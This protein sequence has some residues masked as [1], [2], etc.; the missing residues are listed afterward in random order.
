MSETITPRLLVDLAVVAAAVFALALYLRERRRSRG[1]EQATGTVPPTV[2]SAEIDVDLIPSAAGSPRSPVNPTVAVT[3]S[4]SADAI[5]LGYP[6]DPL[7]TIRPAPDFS[8]DTLE[9]L[10][11]TDDLRRNLQHLFE[12]APRA[13]IASTELATELTSRRYLLIFSKDVRTRLST[14]AYSY[15]PISTEVGPPG[16]RSLAVD[17]RSRKFIEQGRLVRAINPAVVVGVVFQLASIATAQKYLADIEKR[18]AGIE[19][20]VGEL[21]RFQRH[22][23]DA[24]VE[25]LLRH[26]HRMADM[27]KSCDLT[28]RSLAVYAIKLEDL[29]VEGGR[30]MGQL[31]RLFAD[32]VSKFEALPTGGSPQEV[33]KAGLRCVEQAEAAGR[34]YLVSAAIRV[35]GAEV[36]GAVGLHEAHALAILCE[37]EADLTE[38]ANQQGQLVAAVPGAETKLVRKYRTAATN[39]SRQAQMRT[40]V[41]ESARRLNEGMEVIR[42]MIESTRVA[43]E[44]GGRDVSKSASVEITVDERGEITGAR[45][46]MLSHADSTLPVGEAKAT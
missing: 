34:R 21:H 33:L 19:Q 4:E 43:I 37:V 5:V 13:L 44:D 31:R 28:E 38:F 32:E 40:I 14:G 41:E 12:Q 15:M 1:D 29:D 11:L 7:L 17:T 42:G 24:T 2:Q 16:I 39:K 30:I 22:E 9:E 26:V 10:P 36:R 35:T 20:R 18:L 25:S 27:I 8:P 46:L 45:R 6:D 23:L 3:T